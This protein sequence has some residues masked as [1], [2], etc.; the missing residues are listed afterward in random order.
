M[1]SQRK[2]ILDTNVCGKLLTPAYVTDIEQITKRINREFRVVVSPETFLELLDAVK[3][4]DGTH[5]ETDK[6]RLQLMRGTRKPEFLA[7]PG[8]FALEKVLGLKSKVSKFGPADFNQW[9]RVVLHAK[10]RDQ[11]FG[12]NVRLPSD[13]RRKTW[14]F[15]PAKIREQQ[16]EGKAHHRALM[17]KVRDKN[18]ILPPPN[19]WAA[20]IAEA[21]GQRLNQQQA[22]L[23]ACGLDAAYQ[24]DAELCVIVASGKYNFDK[25]EGDWIDNQQLFYLCD[26]D[27]LLLTDDRTLRDRIRRSKQKDRVLDLRDFLKQQGFAPRD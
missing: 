8:T 25:H 14:G 11:L 20:S 9:L 24:Y 18:G 6:Q 26:P 23:L 17:E 19:I 7:F 10:S 13:R 2:L 4:G 5:F 1:P 12:G 21:L 22:D 3:G 16:A 27:T 15:D